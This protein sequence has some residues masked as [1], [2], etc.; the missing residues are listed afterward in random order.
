MPRKEMLEH[1]IAIARSF[2]PFPEGDMDRMRKTLQPSRQGL[3]K[4][5]S[6]HHDGPT[7]KPHLFWV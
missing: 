1:N 3:E 2:S 6:G 7:E 4:N 5:L